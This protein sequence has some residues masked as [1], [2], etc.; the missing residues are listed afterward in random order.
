MIS[1]FNLILI[2]YK[3]INQNMVKVTERGILVCCNSDVPPPSRLKSTILNVGILP[4]LILNF[5]E[6]VINFIF[7]TL[8]DKVAILSKV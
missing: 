5:F 1:L 2:V 3:V 6:R 7:A 4:F 8:P